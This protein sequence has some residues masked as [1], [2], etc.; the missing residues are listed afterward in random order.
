MKFII[1]LSPKVDTIRSLV[2][3]FICFVVCVLAIAINTKCQRAL[4]NP[5]RLISLFRPLEMFSKSQRPNEL[6]THARS[7][8]CLRT[9]KETHRNSVHQTKYEDTL[10]FVYK[11]NGIRMIKQTNGRVSI[12]AERWTRKDNCVLY[13]CSCFLLFCLVFFLFR[14]LFVLWKML[15]Q[16]I[17]GNSHWNILKWN[18][19]VNSNKI[20]WTVITNAR[21]R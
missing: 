6:V 1:N 10:S 20:W 5:L 9:I 17:A 11:L 16:L 7:Y 18:E 2:S 15:F 19:M 3:V 21:K 4:L 8:F 12:Y 14:I 13:I